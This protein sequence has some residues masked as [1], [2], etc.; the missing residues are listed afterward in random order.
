MKTQDLHTIL[1]LTLIEGLG[2]VTIAKI[3]SWIKKNATDWTILYQMTSD[4]LRAECLINYRYIPLLVKGLANKRLL[5]D[6]LHLIEK[7]RVSFS[8]LF[9]STYPELL[10]EIHAPPAVL[11]WRGT[12]I[13][14][15]NAVAV[16]GSRR[17]NHYAQ[18][19]INRI[20]PEL[21][22][23]GAAIV[24]GGALGADTMAHRATLAAHGITAVIL[25]SG[26]LRP[27]PRENQKL[28]DA[29]ADRN[30]VVMSSFPLMTSPHPGNFPAR[31]RIIAGLSRALI[32]VQAAAKSGAAITAQYALDEGREVYAV[33]GAIDDEL[34]E[35]C[36]ALIAQGATLLQKASD[37]SPAKVSGQSE[38]LVS[39][40]D[41]V[42]HH[43]L[44]SQV[45]V[46]E[47]C[48]E[49]HIVNLCKEPQTLDDL[50]ASTGRER[51]QL[52]DLLFELQLSGRLIQD[53]AGLW[54]AS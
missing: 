9:D 19:V 17:A 8:T 29:V 10:K 18:R 40:I 27:Y 41:V 44:S 13:K 46:S 16:V 21:V 28:F 6:E 11:Y 15:S 1:H 47:L 5:D 52:L 37:V 54:L 23:Q 39:V 32:I 36:H 34:S 53:F 3:G 22:L 7:Y 38:H 45:P 35:G 51:T 30:G 33:P 26:L 31:N 50:V 2:P 42:N 49:D 24:S 12:L 4:Q 48:P 25:G 20:V 14:H 43:G